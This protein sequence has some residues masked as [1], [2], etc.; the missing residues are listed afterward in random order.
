MGKEDLTV[1][2]NSDKNNEARCKFEYIYSTYSG[3][4]YN[5]VMR[6][7][8]GNKYLAEEITQITFMKLWEKLSTLNNEVAMLSY[9][10]AIARNQFL[11][12][13][14]HEAIEYVYYNYIMRQISEQDCSTEKQLNEGFFKE[15][16]IKLI[17]ELPPQRKKVFELSKLEGKSNKEIAEE[18]HLSTNTVERHVSMALQQIRGKL[19]KYYNVLCPTVVLLSIG[20]IY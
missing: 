20:S 11:N 7:T 10:Y 2:N 3:R 8:S 17:D 14:E 12:H 6:M 13:C 4:I 1:K 16:L 18:M 9:L 15:F 5:F 19:V